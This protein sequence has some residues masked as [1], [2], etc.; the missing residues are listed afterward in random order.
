MI[1]SGLPTTTLCNA[2]DADLFRDLFPIDLAKVGL[3]HANALLVVEV[4]V[5]VCLL[6]LARG[7]LQWNLARM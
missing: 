2:E 3:S 7:I 6:D 1:C 5:P 4:H